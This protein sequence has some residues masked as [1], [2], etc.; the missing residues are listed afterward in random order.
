MI[1]SV[2]MIGLGNMGSAIA[3]AIYKG[4]PDLN[5]NLMDR[6]IDRTQKL[7]DDL[8]GQVFKLDQLKELIDE[9]Q[10]IIIGIKPKDISALMMSLKPY[11]SEKQSKLWISMA[12]STPLDWLTS[13]TPSNHRWIRIM[14]NTPVEVNQ[15]WI[16]YCYSDNLFEDDE[17]DFKELMNE[18]GHLKYIAEDLFDIAGAMA[19]SSPAFIY[20]LIEAMSDAGVYHGLSR[21]DAIEMAAQTVLGSAQMV[22]SSGRHPGQ[23][24][25]AVTSPGGTTI[26]GVASLEQSG[27]RSAM[28]QAIDQTYQYSVKLNEK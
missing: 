24:K 18:A 20:Q 25:D 9:S 12:V 15:G 2:G 8:N 19:G 1:K 5:F 6:N 7:A 17:D 11:L 21:Q 10:V 22:L 28:I 27:F 13:F 16:S 14:P 3:K 23:L 26:R 4:N